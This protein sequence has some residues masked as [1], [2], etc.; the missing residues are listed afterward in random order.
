[1]LTKSIWPQ[2]TAIE[3]RKMAYDRV[4]LE[5]KKNKE[6]I[7]RRRSKE[8]GRRTEGIPAEMQVLWMEREGGGWEKKAL[9]VDLDY[10]LG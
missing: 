5:R 2:Q 4:V 7:K 6:G 9:L 10:M 1:M 8:Q 3:Q